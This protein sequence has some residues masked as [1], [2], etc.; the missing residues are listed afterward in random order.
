ML[1]LTAPTAR[2]TSV[3]LGK[4]RRAGDGLTTVGLRPPASVHPRRLSHPDCRSALTLIVALHPGVKGAEGR[5]VVKAHQADARALQ[6]RHTGGGLGLDA[7]NAT[8]ATLQV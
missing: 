2:R 7:W 6:R 5:W 4:T 3:H 1:R 8:F